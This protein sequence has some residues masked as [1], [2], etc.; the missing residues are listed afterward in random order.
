MLRKVKVENGVLE[1]LPGGNSRI[2]VFKGIPFAAPPVADNR[3]RAPQ[4]CENWEGV[5]KAFQFGPISVQ[6]TPGL[7]TDIYSR[8]WHVDSE[9]PM[10][11]DCLYLNVY[12]P[13]KEENEKLPV[14]VWYFGGA[15]QWGYPCEM[16]FD[17]EQLA[18]KGVILVTVNY[19]L[20]VFG[21]LT[22]SE[23]L[24]KQ[25]LMLLEILDF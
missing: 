22:C 5:K 4:P 16:E 11:E 10:N 18:K 8:E 17:G 6:D 24:E 20:N 19:R 21:F 15:Y 1:G 12:T 9:I 14:I 2:T 7:G 13:A 23:L 25:L 3:W